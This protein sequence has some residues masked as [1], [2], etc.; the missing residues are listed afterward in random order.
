MYHKEVGIDKN[1]T[2]AKDFFGKACAG[3]NERGCK[4]HAILNQKK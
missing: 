1:T 2:K 3:K 4:A